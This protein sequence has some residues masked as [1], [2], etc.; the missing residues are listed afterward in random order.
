MTKPNIKKLEKEIEKM[1]TYQLGDFRYIPYHRR[2]SILEMLR[3]TIKQIVESVPVEVTSREALV[4]FKTL[5]QEIKQW[6]EKI[7]E[8]IR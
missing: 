3:K 8:E 4:E 1:Y 6:K 7:L 2:H 5:S